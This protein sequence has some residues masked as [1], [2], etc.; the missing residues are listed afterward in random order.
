MVDDARDTVTVATGGTVTVTIADPLCP[1]LAAMMLAVPGA[2]PATT[3]VADTVATPVLSD[4]QVIGRPVRTLP[5]ASLRVAV[6]FVVAPIT[7]E[8]CAMLTETPA[9][10]GGP[11]PRPPPPQPNAATH[12]TTA[13]RALNGIG[14]PLSMPGL[15][16]AETQ[17]GGKP[18]AHKSDGL[19]RGPTT[20]RGRW[21]PPG[22]ALAQLPG[23]RLP[24]G[25]PPGP[26]GF[27]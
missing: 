7:I 11:A 13:V 20:P 24:G 15:R 10:A 6:A 8:G 14:T 12:N 1:S 23:G 27:V 2:T 22:S 18:R 16:R 25:G 19:S 26:I 5:P 3:P 21:A 17:Y 4:D 9:T